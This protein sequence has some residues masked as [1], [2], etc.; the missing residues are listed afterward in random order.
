MKLESLRTILG[1][2]GIVTDPSLNSAYT[3]D[4]T[5]RYKGY[6][7]AVLLPRTTGQVSQIVKWCYENAIALVPQ[8]GNT[9]MVG[10]ATPV[11]GELVLSLK[12]MTAIE[13]VDDATGQ[14]VTQAGATL[15]DVQ[16]AASQVGW[17]YGVDLSARDSA[18]I[19]GTIATN[20]GGSQV[21]RYGNTR[22]QVLSLEA[23]SGTGDVIGD[24][25]G[26]PKDNTGYHLPGLLC[27]SEGTLAVVTRA[28]LRL[29]KPPEEEL[30][31][32]LGFRSLNEA[33]EIVEEIRKSLD[34]VQACEIFFHNGLSL[35]CER[36]EIIPPWNEQLAAYLLVGIGGQPGLEERISNSPLSAFFN[37][38]HFVA[39]GNDSQSRKKLWQYRDLHTEAISAAGVPHKLDVS[40]PHGK[41]NEFCNNVQEVIN[42]I[43]DQ[44]QSFLFGHAGDG[45]IH[46]NILGPDPE[47]LEVDIAVLKYVASLGGS[48]S[49][50]HG[51]GRAKAHHLYLNRTPTEINIFQEI[52]S[53]FDPAGILNPG[54]ILPQQ[55]I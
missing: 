15:G 54:T 10:G 5:R 41:L 32:L 11:N 19:G 53:V 28:R 9:G 16:Q 26:L 42:A 17:K 36:F 27:G 49:A 7:P 37:A 34:D 20:A 8:G 46:V 2:D 22:E 24:L 44:T 6:T 48:I 13:E 23:V 4:W 12:R 35:V 52:K 43:D 31:I 47:D 14:I 21:L 18:S 40:L 51:I 33:L 3:V 30:S 1:N 39:Y 29:V 50:E 55:E 45:N 38:S 25:R